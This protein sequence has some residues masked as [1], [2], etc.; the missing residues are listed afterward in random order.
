MSQNNP[1]NK[2]V[3]FLAAIVK[4]A[5]IATTLDNALNANEAWRRPG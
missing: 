1:V 4:T 2:I 5:A 3:D